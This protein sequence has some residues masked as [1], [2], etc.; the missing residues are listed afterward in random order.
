MKTR[1]YIVCVL[2]FFL[3]KCSEDPKIDPERQIVGTKSISSE[4]G[5]MALSNINGDSVILEIPR[6]ALSDAV[7]ITMKV[8]DNPPECPISNIIFPGVDLEPHGLIFNKPVQIKIKFSKNIDHAETISIFNISQN[9][10][11]RLKE[12]NKISNSQI[13]AEIIHFSPYSAGIPTLNEIY[14]LI[15]K[16]QVY[17]GDANALGIL[18]M[19]D[20]VNSMLGFAE[21]LEVLDQSDKANDVRDAALG[22]LEEKSYVILDNIPLEPSG[23]YLTSLDYLSSILGKYL[24][25]SDVKKLLDIKIMELEQQCEPDNVEGGCHFIDERDGQE[26]KCVEIGEQTWMAENLKATKYNDG[27]DIPLVTDNTEWGDLST[28]GYCW[29]GNDAATYKTPYGALYNWHAV[30][31][32]KLC[33]TGWHVPTDAEWTT[34]T[35]YLGGEEVAGGK[36]KEAGTDHW[37]YPNV[38]ATNS[39]GFTALG[40]GYRNYLHGIFRYVNFSGWWWSSTEFDYESDEEYAF[41]RYI[42][43]DKDNINRYGFVPKSEGI[44]VRCLRD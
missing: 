43:H 16:I 9:K 11:I 25:S 17:Q 33:P 40:G 29:Y 24:G 39:S 44:S 22:M 21:L 7:N 28:P 18:Y 32:G 10:E 2:S 4:G 31:T 6:D 12:T 3:L 13:Y 41:V 30:N 23:Q 20:D 35:D 8:L 34:L 26:Y 36:L 19:L 5:R 1:L 14:D 15:N 42:F 37:R 27:T 38:G